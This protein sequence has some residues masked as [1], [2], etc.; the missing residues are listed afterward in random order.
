MDL[1]I[2]ISDDFENPLA[3]FINPENVSFT[4][5]LV[6]S[7]DMSFSLDLFDPQISEI[8]EFKKVELCS[9]ENG[10]DFVLWSGV[11]DE[12][13]NDFNF[14]TVLC[15]GEKDWLKRKC[16]LTDKNW[17]AVNIP[18]A[19][20]AIINE[21]NARKGA[22]ELAL[23]YVTSLSDVIGKQYLSGVYYYDILKD[24]A[25][26]FDCEWDV[27]RNEII[28]EPTIGTDRTVS[29][30]DYLAFIWNVNSPNENNIINF[31]NIRRGSQLATRVIGKDKAG[32]EFVKVGDLDVFGSVEQFVSFNEGNIETQTQE[33]LNKR[34]VSQQEKSFD[35]NISVEDFK[36][37][38]VG[39]LVDVLVEL[40][41]P[42]V[43]FSG[44]LKVLKKTCSFEN[45]TPNTSIVLSTQSKS[46]VTMESFLSELSARTRS[47]ELS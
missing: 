27:V 35:V 6:E 19:L 29:G 28:I 14:V 33:F 13:Q 26:L 22:S 41:S 16:I 18:T 43:D 7:G 10:E 11:I 37:V 30:D 38:K 21:A 23:S 34:A 39:D 25:E 5:D 15:K 20:T 1:V 2:K 45:K 32:N 17:S 4:S 8:V 9:I 12:I 42:L 31:Q 46:V 44:S 40:G 24:I 3:Q 47:L 36:K